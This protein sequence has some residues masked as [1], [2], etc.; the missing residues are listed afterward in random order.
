MDFDGLLWE[1]NE[2]SGIVWLVHSLSAQARPMA[3]LRKDDVTAYEEDNEGRLWLV[4][5][6]LF[7]S[8]WNDE[9]DSNGWQL[10]GV[11]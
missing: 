7:G 3:T 11:V 10:P 5:Q 9:L 2:V 4:L 6:Q 1:N 8:N